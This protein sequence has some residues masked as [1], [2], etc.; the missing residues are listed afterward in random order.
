MAKDSKIEWTHHTFN[1][2]WGCAK[3]SPAC[4]NCYAEAWAKRVGNDIWGKDSDRRFFTDKHWSEPI[5]WNREA[6]SCGER[7]RV[8]C[9]SMADVFERK[10]GLERWRERLWALIEKTPYLDWLLLTKRPQ[11]IERMAP[12]AG[13]LW[14][15]NV[16]LGTTVENQHWAEVRLPHLLK[17]GAKVRFLSCEPLLGEIDL[18][19][20][21]RDQSLHKIDWVIAGGESGASSRP[22]NPEWARSLRDQARAEGVAFHFKQWGHWA[23]KE[24]LTDKQ[25]KVVTI[26]ANVMASA[27]KK[28]AGRELDGRTWDE[29]PI[30]ALA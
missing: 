6:E 14:P 25:R 28:A 19:R 10:A 30:A 16:W 4:R 5:K 27:G 18:T 7:R 26:G 1:P 2:W 24:L 17:H 11:N 3:V 8:F 29:L 15:E 23:P 13:G 22:M 12:W 9:A 21:A 20:W